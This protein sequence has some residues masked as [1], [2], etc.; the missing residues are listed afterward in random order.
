[1]VDEY[2]EDEDEKCNP[3]SD[4]RYEN[5][6][7]EERIARLKEYNRQLKR[8]QNSSHR[9][10]VRYR[11]LQE[12]YDWTMKPRTIADV[13]RNAY[14]NVSDVFVIQQAFHPLVLGFFNARNNILLC[15]TSSND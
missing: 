3:V 15:T 9:A 11:V 5:L 7:A 10:L 4:P 13:S 8:I 14:L 12:Y 2:V 1:M 6:S